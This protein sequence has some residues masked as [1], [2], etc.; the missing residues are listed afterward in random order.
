M[1]AHCEETHDDK[2]EPGPTQLSLCA[3]QPELCLSFRASPLR[4]QIVASSP[5]S[6]LPAR[7]ILDQSDFSEI[8]GNYSP[9]ANVLIVQ[10][11]PRPRSASPRL[12]GGSYAIRHTY[13]SGTVARS[14]VASSPARLLV[15]RGGKLLVRRIREAYEGAQVPLV[16]S[17]SMA[18]DG[19]AAAMVA[20]VASLG[21]DAFQRGRVSRPSYL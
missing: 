1:K 16:A 12:I 7:R 8:P 14:G 3:G 19:D 10:R 18:V 15:S 21:E 4:P 9:S 13:G 11:K 20:K 6:N 17:P 5:T 2:L